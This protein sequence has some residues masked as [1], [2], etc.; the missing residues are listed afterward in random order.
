M[1]SFFIALSSHLFIAAVGKVSVF[2]FVHTVE[3]PRNK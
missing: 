3:V 1:H 2:Y